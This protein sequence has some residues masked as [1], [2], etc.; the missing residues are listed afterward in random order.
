MNKKLVLGIF[1]AFSAGAFWACGSGDVVESDDNL[2]GLAVALLDQ[3]GDVEVAKAVS[4]CAENPQCAAEMGNAPSLAVQSSSSSSKPASSSATP[5]SSGTMS[6]SGLNLSFGPVGHKSSSSNTPPPSSATVQSSS[7]IVVPA[8]QYGYCTPSAKTA[9][10]KEKVTWTFN[11]DTK[12]SGVGTSDILAATYSWEFPDGSPAT[13]AAKAFATAYEVSGPKTASVTVSTPSHGAQTIACAE[14]ININGS[15]ITGCKCESTN[16][17]PDVSTGEVAKWTASGCTTGTGF[18]LTYAWTGA[19]PDATGL[20]ATAPVAEKGDEVKGVVLTVANDDNT[21]V[22][23]PCADAKAQD[24]TKP[25]YEFIIADAYPEKPITIGEPGC[26]TVHGTWT[27]EYYK[28]TPKMQCE[29]K[30]TITYGTKTWSNMN[31]NDGSVTTDPLKAL[32]VSAEE[33][34]FIE[35]ICVEGAGATCKLSN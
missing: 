35:N 32:V 26:I 10:L 29:G 20:V 24:K 4:T 22:N 27:N 21:V 7:S 13:G 6:S 2:E 25:D 33:T 3:I 1:V 19:T 9:E 15:P 18:T 8:G 17:E 31:N 30:I 11:W 34:V 12:T 14:G 16:I 5:K 28:P 23:I